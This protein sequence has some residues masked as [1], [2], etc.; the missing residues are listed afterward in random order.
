MPDLEEDLSRLFRQVAGSASAPGA[1]LVRDVERRYTRRRGTLTALVAGVAVLVVLVG[2]MGA[3]RVVGDDPRPSKPITPAADGPVTEVWPTALRRVP[4]TLP[5]G[6]QYSF[7]GLLPDGRF[8]VSTLGGF[9]KI[10]AL[11]V[12]DPDAGTAEKVVTLADRPEGRAF[13][14]R[15]LVDDDWVVWSIDYLDADSNAR[16]SEVWAM[17]VTT[18]APKRV[19]EWSGKNVRGPFDLALTDGVVRWRSLDGIGE[20]PLSGGTPRV[21]P[22]TQ[23]YGVVSWPW[24]GSPPPLTRESQGK[25][26]YGTQRNLVTGERRVAKTPTA[27]NFDGSCSV[28]WCVYRGKQYTSSRFDGSDRRT[29]SDVLES[30]GMDGGIIR[31]RYLLLQPHMGTPKARLVVVDLTNNRQ[32]VLGP[33]VTGADGNT[34]AIRWTSDQFIAWTDNNRKPTEYLVLDLSKVD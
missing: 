31:D 33:V 24:I 12:W 15:I 11:W 22:G 26:V 7:A 2:G 25:M 32:V 9:E 16:A 14:Q 19:A 20:V 18:L 28:T 17:P 34:S 13:T 10:D 6:K 4:L 3:V 8:V 27:K 21:L 1:E 23:G 29:Y 5:N 30:P